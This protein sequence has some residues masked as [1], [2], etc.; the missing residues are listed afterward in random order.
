MQGLLPPQAIEYEEG[1]L[2][3]CLV[4]HECYDT[5]K[6]TLTPDYFYKPRHKTIFQA[7]LKCDIPD[8]LSVMQVLRDSGKFEEVGE[9]S[10]LTKY[11]TSRVDHYL[12]VIVERYHRR[13]MIGELSNSI[14]MLYDVTE[15]LE[16]IQDK[17]H[18][19]SIIGDVDN[20]LINALEII[21]REK[22]RPKAEQLYT[23]YKQLD[24]G[25]LHHG[26]KRGRTI[27][28]IAD[29][30]HGKTQ[31]AMFV[32][33]KL[34]R[35][36]C[37]IAWFQLEGYDA[38]T[39]NYMHTIAGSH[40]ENI[41]IADSLFDIESIKRQCRI[42]KKEIGLDYVVIDYIQNVE[43]GNKR[44]SKTEQTENVSKE[45]TR[46]AKELNIVMNPLSQVTIS[47]DSRP[48]WKAEPKYGDVRWSQQL[49]QDAAL[50]LSVFRPAKI[51]SLIK[52]SPLG[53]ISVLNWKQESV[54]YNSVF[55]KQAKNRYG[56]QDWRRL[57]LI[58]T[59]DKGLQI[60]ENFRESEGGK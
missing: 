36:G 44:L 3:T 51:E 29:S 31:F 52:E 37:K 38:D 54:N 56:E 21:E 17:V 34:L 58:H 24:E 59:Y 19:S 15:P 45:I 12:D 48:G 10:E 25:L 20:G 6:A 43:H 33:E 49:K 11:C 46:L 14:R 1:I 18:N 22:T 30:G 42:M 16:V 60:L 4:L 2:G 5:I 53:S 7:M 41:F 39:A 32:A 35:K 40:A 57:H 8:T 9:I 55:I 50:I 28:T 27:L 26:M 47:Y 23:G 13:K